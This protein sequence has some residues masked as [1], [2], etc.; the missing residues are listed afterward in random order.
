MKRASRIMVAV[1]ILSSFGCA[2]MR[3]F[4]MNMTKIERRLNPT[5]GQITPRI[6][7]EQFKYYSGEP[8]PYKPYTEMAEIIIQGKP[9]FSEKPPLIYTKTPDDMLHYMCKAAWENGADAV[10]NVSFGT[11]NIQEASTDGSEFRVYGG[12]NGFG[13]GGSVSRGDD[14]PDVITF[15]VVKGIAVRFNQ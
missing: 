9:Q 11:E 6:S 14:E 5:Y 12:G 3:T 1:A 4:D 15:S 7:F 10:I 2:H 8:E 13:V